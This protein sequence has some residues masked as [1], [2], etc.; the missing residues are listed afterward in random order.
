MIKLE[1]FSCGYPGHQVLESVD[2]QIDSGT[3]TVVIGQNGSGK[4]TLAQVLAGI[5]TDF[6]GKVWLD[7]LRLKRST[8]IRALRQKLGMVLQNPD[9]QILFDRVETEISFALQNLNLPALPDLPK[10]HREREAMLKTERREIIQ[11]TLVQVG[12]GDKIDANPR[13]LSGGQ[14]QRLALASVLALRPKYLVLDEATSLLDLPSRRAI[15]QVLQRLKRQGI[16]ILMMTNLLDEILLADKVL[17]LDNGQIYQ[18]NPA[19]IIDQPELLV[20]HGLEIPLLLQVAQSLKVTN[21]EDLQQNLLNS[22]KS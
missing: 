10:K 14:K 22:S 6:S 11:A 21:L 18:Y 15:Y 2:L 4:S 9:H 1:Q 12:L 7:D 3:I 8:P 20:K 13:E 19:E 17:L 16:G 5:K